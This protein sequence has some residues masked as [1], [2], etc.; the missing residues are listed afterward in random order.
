MAGNKLTR[1]A[2]C[3]ATQTTN[4]GMEMRSSWKR[5]AKARLIGA[6]LAAFFAMATAATA[7]MAQERLEQ[8]FGIIKACAGDVWRLCSDVLPESDA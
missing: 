4:G 8:D 5:A 6:G 3:E 1:G 2:N 7:A